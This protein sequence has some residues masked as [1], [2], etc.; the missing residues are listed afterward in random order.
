MNL[1]VENRGPSLENRIYFCF[2][3]DSQ[4]QSSFPINRKSSFGEKTVY[5]SGK[6]VVFGVIQDWFQSLV[7]TSVR[8]F[9]KVTQPPLGGI[10]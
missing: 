10:K 6:N 7:L 1:K 8:T 9:E 2:L 5:R 3:L 4:V